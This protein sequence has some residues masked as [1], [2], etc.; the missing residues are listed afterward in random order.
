M[1]GY[2]ERPDETEA[3]LLPDGWLRTGDLG[4]VD[5][6]GRLYLLDRVKDL[7]VSG[8]ENISPAEIETV[9]RGHPAVADVAVIGVR[10]LR[11]GETPLALVVPSGVEPV[12]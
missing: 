1:C 7:I 10:S 5:D 6:R 4:M 2:W 3:A 9:L 11:W 8:G 12:E